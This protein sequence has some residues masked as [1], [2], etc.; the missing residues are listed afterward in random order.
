MKLS[1]LLFYISLTFFIGETFITPKFCQTIQSAKSCKCKAMP[2]GITKSQ[3]ICLTSDQLKNRATT[4]IP[5][6]FPGSSGAIEKI[7]DKT[8]TVDVFIDKSGKVIK[9]VAS[10]GHPL[11]K[12]SA[13]FVARRIEFQPIKV[14][15]KA[16]NICGSI[17]FEW[18]P[19]EVVSKVVEI[20]KR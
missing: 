6:I 5:E 1:C 17:I 2:K 16:M 15:G 14:N 13:V 19:N 3:V 18:K 9:A 20:E 8:V 12:P 11:L 7:K 10:K 4:S